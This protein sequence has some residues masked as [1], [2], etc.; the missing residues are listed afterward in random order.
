MAGHDKRRQTVHLPEEVLKEMANEAIRLDR[1]LSWIV[2]NAWLRARRDIKREAPF[3]HA[4]A[5]AAC[6]T[7]T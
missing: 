2:Q 3:R 5:A 7:S 1:S 4:E 6:G